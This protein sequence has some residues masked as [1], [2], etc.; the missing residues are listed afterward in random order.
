MAHSGWQQFDDVFEGRSPG[1]VS[2][3]EIKAWAASVNAASSRINPSEHEKVAIN[4][5]IGTTLEPINNLIG[6]KNIQQD[7]K[8]GLD[9]NELDDFLGS[10]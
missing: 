9:G 7:V 4:N 8:Q 2:E 3:D 6:I 1:E 10:R 5:L